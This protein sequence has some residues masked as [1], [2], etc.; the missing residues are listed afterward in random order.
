MG[1]DQKS[2]VLKREQECM[3]YAVGLRKL[4]SNTEKDSMKLTNLCLASKK[5]LKW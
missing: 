2:V 3:A 1:E 4:A 5:Q